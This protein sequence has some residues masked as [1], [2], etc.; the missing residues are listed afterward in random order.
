MYLQGGDAVTV[1]SLIV[2]CAMNQDPASDP[3]VS[4]RSH[5]GS[6]RPDCLS[7]PTGSQ[8]HRKSFSKKKNQ[9]T[10][11]EAVHQL[12]ACQEGKRLTKSMR[13][14]CASFHKPSALPLENEVRKETSSEPK[15]VFLLEE[16]TPLPRRNQRSMRGD[17]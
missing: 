16:K 1:N 5:R 7:S 10:P 11:D 12:H 4:S 2:R 17:S 13:K 15:L 3:P 8:V 14:P 6:A 9:S